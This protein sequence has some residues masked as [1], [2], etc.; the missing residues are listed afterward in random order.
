MLLYVQK[1]LFN[2]RTML[3]AVDEENRW[4]GTGHSSHKT[5]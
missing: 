2:M 3:Q 4:T 5:W 1:M